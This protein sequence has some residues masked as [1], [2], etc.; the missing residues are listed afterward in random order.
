M[1]I[2]ILIIIFFTIFLEWNWTGYLLFLFSFFPSNISY[3]LGSWTKCSLLLVLFCYSIKKSRDRTC[4]QHVPA[5]SKLLFL[6]YCQIESREDL[7][8]HGIDTDQFS[9]CCGKFV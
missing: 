4:Q 6:G 2:Y 9:W 5:T 8:I 7:Y 3:N 1:L